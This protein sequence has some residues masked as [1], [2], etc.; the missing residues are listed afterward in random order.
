MLCFPPS[1]LASKRKK[2]GWPMQRVLF[3]ALF[4]WAILFALSTPARACAVNTGTNVLGATISP[5]TISGNETEFATVSIQVCQPPPPD[6]PDYVQVLF[7]ASGFSSTHA[8]AIGGSCTSNSCTWSGLGSGM[9]TVQIQLNGYNGSTVANNGT[10]TVGFGPPYFDEPITVLPAAPSQL[11]CCAGTAGQ[12][13]N[14]LNG[15]TW[16][17]PARL[18]PAWLGRRHRARPHLE[19]SV[20]DRKH[21]AASPSRNVRRQLAQ[22]L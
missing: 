8:N 2:P 21:V 11:S 5:S 19:Q 10:V 9:L 20:A 13:I 1:V 15:N 18:R 22:H 6:A 16:V 12:P 7:Y 17:Y 3:F 4:C 14:L